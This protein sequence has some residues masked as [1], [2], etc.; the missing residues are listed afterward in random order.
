MGLGD[1]GAASAVL[2][3]G[4]LGGTLLASARCLEELRAEFGR[5]H[6]VRLRG[7]LEPG[8]LEWLLGEIDRAT[9][10][11][12]VHSGIGPNRE[13]CM[14][15]NALAGVLHVLFNSDLVFG[16]VRRIAGCE[17][18]E[19]LTGRVY[20]VVPGH[21]HFDAWH[22]DVGDH[23]MVA[24]SLN[25]GR[26]AF[27]GGA[28]QIREKATRKLLCEVANTGPGDALLFRLR[29]GLEHRITEVTGTAAKT[30]F[31]GWFR[32]HPPFRPRD[33]MSPETGG[34]A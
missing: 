33:R 31:A 6:C 32:S 1:G 17:R 3:I 19:N 29:D 9:F 8:L 30:A 22:S 25:L 7:L 5:R 24:M 23:R 13:L 34:R 20:R 11:T 14:E 15:R 28:L 27:S 18:I 4:R 2:R 26:E 21:G 12:R 16:V 10:S